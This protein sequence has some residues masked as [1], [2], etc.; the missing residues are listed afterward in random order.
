M[1][2]T[3]RKAGHLDLQ[4][5]YKRFKTQEDCIKYLEQIRW[6]GIPRCP[7]CH[8]TRQTPQPKEQRY[9]C[10][11]CRSSYSVMVRTVFH[12]TKIDLQKWFTVIPL[13]IKDRM[14]VRQIAKAIQVSKDTA[15][16]MIERVRIAHR[17][18]PELINKFL[19][20]ENGK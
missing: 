9:H 1:Y 13:V 20:L 15:C 3:Y 8:T 12:N 10:G 7:H 4:Q 5:T 14:S 19:N 18:E 6:N 16:L 11:V 2:L 17:E